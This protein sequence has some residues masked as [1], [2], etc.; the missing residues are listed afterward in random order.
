MPFCSSAE[1][2]AKYAKKRLAENGI[3]IFSTAHPLSSAELLDIEDEHGIFLPNY[4]KIPDDVRFDNKG[5]EEIRSKFY[6]VS[7]IASAVSAAGMVI[8][9]I[10]EPQVDLNNLKKSPYLSENWLEYS[11]MFAIIPGTIIFSCSL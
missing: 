11:E 9:N 8:R 2:F 5:N 6:T 10:Y 4:F 3:F 1:E 7:E